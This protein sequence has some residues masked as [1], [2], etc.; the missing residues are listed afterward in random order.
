MVGGIN[1]LA[2]LDR[3]DALGV[4]PLRLTGTDTDLLFAG[5][6]A[7]VRTFTERPRL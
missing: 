1:D 5:A 6:A 7:R 3:F 4:G 2:V